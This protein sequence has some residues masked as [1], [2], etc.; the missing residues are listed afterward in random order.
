VCGEEKP[1]RAEIRQPLRGQE[2]EPVCRK[3]NE[4][5]RRKQGESVCGEEPVRREESLRGQEVRP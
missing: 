3:E 1:L 4:S 5:L 2:E